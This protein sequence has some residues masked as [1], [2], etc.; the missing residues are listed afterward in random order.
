VFTAY[1]GRTV[2]DSERRSTTGAARFEFV[3]AQANDPT[4]PTLRIDRVTV[5]VC[6]TAGTNE[7][8]STPFTC[9]LVSTYTP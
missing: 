4:P 9:G 5:Q 6:H 8:T 1:N 7:P 2:V 3:L